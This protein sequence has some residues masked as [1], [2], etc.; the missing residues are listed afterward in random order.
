MPKNYYITT[1]IYYVNDSPHIGHAYTTIAC[2]VMARFKRLDGYDVKFL[3]GTD[4]H[5]QKVDKAAQK[6]GIDAQSFTD[7]VSKRF[8]YLVNSGDNILNITNDDFIRTTE[9]RHKQAAQYLWQ[10]IKDNGHIYLDKYAGWYSVRDE[11][12]YQESELTEKDGKKIA[13]QDLINE[14]G[15]DQTRYFLM[16]EVP[17][18]NDGNFA[19]DA[20]IER[21]NSELANNIGNLVQRTLSMIQKN[22]GRVVPSNDS[23]NAD[24]KKLLELAHVTIES[25]RSEKARIDELTDNFKFDFIIADILSVAS[26]ANE[27]IDQQQ[28]WKLKKE[29]P[30]RMQTVLY[31][32]AEVIRCIAIMLQPFTPV[33][34]RNILLQVGYSEKDFENAAGG[35]LFEQLKVDYALKP[36][37]ELP[38]P[39]GVFPR[40]INER[41]IC[42]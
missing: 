32:L 5:G 36:G 11:A 2:D 40:F 15:C 21:V 16:R 29:D 17:F 23:L 6:A 4:E 12:Y 13:P 3:T 20:M 35:V 1:P 26:N 39:K 19:H 24:D 42:G 38:A 28:P 37:K 30:E 22:C 34:A 14:F 27:Y 41:S 10:R 7:D 25:P 9:G 33:A 8:R 18:G 31:T